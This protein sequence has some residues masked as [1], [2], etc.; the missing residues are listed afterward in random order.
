MAQL[1]ALPAPGKKNN[2]GL[3]QA[4]FSGEEALGNEVSALQ[5]SGATDLQPHM[6]VMTDGKNEVMSGDDSQLLN[7]DLGLQQAAAQMQVSHIDTIGIGF[8][9]PAAIDAAAMKR[10]STRFLYA[11]MLPAAGRAAY[12]PAQRQPLHHAHLATA[13]EQ[14]A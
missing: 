7:G 8:G 6:V 10:L 2:T 1:K 12:H 4:V 11:G 13:R 9:D 14:P 3:Y 5:R